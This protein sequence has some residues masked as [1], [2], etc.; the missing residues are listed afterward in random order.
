MALSKPCDSVATANST[1]SR[2]ANCS[3]DALYPSFSSRA[4]RALLAS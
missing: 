1:S 2:G 4:I 3:A